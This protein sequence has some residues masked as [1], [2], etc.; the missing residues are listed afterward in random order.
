[1][2]ILLIV[3][4]F[5]TAL[6]AAY[7]FS[8]LDGP[9]QIFDQP[10]ERSLH[11]TPIPRTGGLAIWAGAI[12]GMVGANVFD[13][14]FELAWLPSAVLLIGLVSFADDWSGVS[15]VS[16]LITHVVA[17]GVLLMDEL[18]LQVIWL[19]GSAISLSPALGMGITVLF[20]VWMTNLYNFMDGMDGF[21]G[22]MAVIGFGAYAVAGSMGGNQTFLVFNVVIAASAAGFLV[23]NFP[24]ARLFMG[25][26]GSSP[27]GFLGGAV[28]LW[29]NRDGILPLWSGIL[30]FSP[31]II[32]AS[33]TLTT[34]VCRRERVWEA[35]KGHYYQ[36]LVQAG[37][38]H[39]KTTLAGYA[40]MAS[41]AASALMGVVSPPHWQWGIIGFWTIFYILLIAAIGRK[42][43]PLIV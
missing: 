9:L 1:M 24:P 31:F 38:G 8:R 22:G 23:F 34:R 32:D 37:W 2:N 4:G 11:S 15:V 17:A 18:T 26:V 13:P 5:T 12:V 43:R 10:N 28:T 29:A 21:A 6:L 20:V 14:Q 25:D 41:C 19:P 35:H 40:L 3:A 27:L 33:V 7:F 30:V 36:R 39:R 42:L 16:R